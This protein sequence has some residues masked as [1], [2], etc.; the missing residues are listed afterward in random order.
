MGSTSLTRDQ[1]Q[2]SCIGSAVLTTGPLVQR[3]LNFFTHCPSSDGL[4][5]PGVSEGHSTDSTSSVLTVDRLCGSVLTATVPLPWPT[6]SLALRAQVCDRG[7]HCPVALLWSVFHSKDRRKKRDSPPPKFLFGK[8]EIYRKV[9][10]IIQRAYV[11]PVAPP[12]VHIWQHS[13]SLSLSLSSLSF[14]PMCLS[15]LT[16]SAEP[17]EY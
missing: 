11:L 8:F 14:F 6:G 16:S 7:K 15:I 1:T 13:F 12:S 3:V 9:T 2:A 5:A 17:S 10:R 4:P